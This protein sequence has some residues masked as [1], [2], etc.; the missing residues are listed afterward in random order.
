[1]TTTIALGNKSNYTITVTM[2]QADKQTNTN[3]VLI[4]YQKEATKPGFRK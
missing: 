1:M 2:S 4:E 3:E